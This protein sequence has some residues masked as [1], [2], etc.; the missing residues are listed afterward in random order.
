M[1][2][3]LSEIFCL[4]SLFRVE[5]SNY[6]I[7]ENPVKPRPLHLDRTNLYLN[8]SPNNFNGLGVFCDRIH[9][10]PMS[11]V[12][13]VLC[14]SGCVRVFRLRGTG[15]DVLR[16]HLRAAPVSGRALRQKTRILECQCRLPPGSHASRVTVRIITVIRTRPGFPVEP[17]AAPA[18][19]GFSHGFT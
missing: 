3:G 1:F 8:L 18:A 9:R 11:D 16:V 17:L 2:F 15:L 4:S 6:V 5:L 10:S 12:L 7:E 13:I 19:L 14:F